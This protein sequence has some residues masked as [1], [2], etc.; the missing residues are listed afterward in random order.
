VPKKVTGYRTARGETFQVVLQ[1]PTAEA[2][3][4]DN[5]GIPAGMPSRTS[6]VRFLLQKRLEAVRATENRQNAG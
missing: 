4:V 3:A 5:L 6:A 2:E 1:M